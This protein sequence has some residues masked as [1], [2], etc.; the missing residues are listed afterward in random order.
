M[1][2]TK[3]VKPVS[4]DPKSGSQGI[5]GDVLVFSCPGKWYYNLDL[6]SV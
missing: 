6:A 4:I 3:P 5:P 2:K 1:D